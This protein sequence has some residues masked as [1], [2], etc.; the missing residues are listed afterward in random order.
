MIDAYALK[1][2]IVTNLL[3]DLEN[4]IRNGSKKDVEA[5]D[6][7]INQILPMCRQALLPDTA[8]LIEI[9]KNRYD[10]NMISDLATDMVH[11]SIKALEEGDKLMLLPVDSGNIEF[12]KNNSLFGHNIATKIPDAQKDLTEA[13]TCY[14]LGC[15]T[16]CVL[17]L[18][19]ALEGALKTY[20][21]ILKTRLSIAFTYQPTDT[22]GQIAGKL[23]EYARDKMPRTTQA[24]IDFQISVNAIAVQFQAITKALRNPA[25]HT[26]EFFSKD[27]ASQVFSGTRFLM[28]ELA[29]II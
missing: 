20:A 23:Y 27:Q 28:D 4:G 25:M 14:A 6:E 10:T 11:L 15:Y 5:M 2:S 19:R 29:D 7:L 22:M 21:N 26:G 17:H 9:T 18:M 8:R 16:A 3:Q 13:G 12:Y 24:E 1:H